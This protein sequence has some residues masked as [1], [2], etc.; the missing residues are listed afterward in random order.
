MAWKGK[1]V[2]CPLCGFNCTV[3]RWKSRKL[4]M[5]P[6]DHELIMTKEQRAPGPNREGGGFFKV[7]GESVPVTDVLTEDELKQLD[8][9][10]RKILEV[11]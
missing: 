11:L 4:E 3:N 9:I 8:K 5:T 7:D 1:Y 10:R 2:K 6:K